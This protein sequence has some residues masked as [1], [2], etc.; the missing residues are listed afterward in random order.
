[1]LCGVQ[2]QRTMGIPESL[3]A[4]AYPSDIMST[5]K[6]EEKKKKKDVHEIRNHS[7]STAVTTGQKSADWQTTGEITEERS[8]SACLVHCLQH[9]CGMKILRM[10]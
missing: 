8:S 6:K 4:S 3:C 1:M 7:L 9:R 5:G 10:T 2:F